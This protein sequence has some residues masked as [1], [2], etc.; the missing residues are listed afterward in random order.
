MNENKKNKNSEVKDKK[1]VRLEHIS[2]IYVDP[3]TKKE[4]YNFKNGCWL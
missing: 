1:G 4:F 3:K 2:K